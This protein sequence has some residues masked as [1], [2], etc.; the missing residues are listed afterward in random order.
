VLIY[1]NIAAVFRPKWYITL[2]MS[3]VIFMVARSFIISNDGQKT[4][5]L[6]VTLIFALLV[7]IIAN[8]CAYTLRWVLVSSFVF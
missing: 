1:T 2:V 3:S 6:V 4:E 7:A 5:E 8:C